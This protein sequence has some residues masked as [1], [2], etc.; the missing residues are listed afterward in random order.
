MD[1]VR[2]AKK[3]IAH[4]LDQQMWYHQHHI[5][6]STLYGSDKGSNSNNNNN[7]INNINNNNNNSQ[8]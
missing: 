6:V 1:E 3:K 2:E 7:K 4:T 5:L 8:Y